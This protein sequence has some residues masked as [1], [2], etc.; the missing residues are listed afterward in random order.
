MNGEHQLVA[1]SGSLHPGK[2]GW[3]KFDLSEGQALAHAVSD[4]VGWGF[5]ESSV[6]A[7]GERNGYS[8]YD[9]AAASPNQSANRRVLGIS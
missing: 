8:E 3:N 4:R 9:F 5:A 2:L 6:E 7:R 1:I